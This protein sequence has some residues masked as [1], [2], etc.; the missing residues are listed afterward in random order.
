MINRVRRWEKIQEAGSKSDSRL[1]E[2]DGEEEEEEEDEEDDE[3]E[4]GE[5]EGEEDEGG[6]GDVE[7]NKKRRRRRKPSQ[8]RLCADSK[9]ESC[10]KKKSG[11]VSRG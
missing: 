8:E 10:K 4:E 7:R 9:A 1:Y 2:E 11:D 6:E 3:E 5:G